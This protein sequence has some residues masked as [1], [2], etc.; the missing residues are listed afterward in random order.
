VSLTVAGRTPLRHSINQAGYHPEM[1]WNAVADALATEDPVAHVVHQETTFDAQE[2]RRHVT[3]L[4]L[5][6]TRL[7]MAHADEQET[8]G[9]PGVAATTEAVPLSRI[10]SVVMS[11]TY[12]RTGAII[13]AVLTIGW[14]AV[15]RI[16]LAPAHCADE[17]CDA[18]HGYSGTISSD[19]VQLRVAAAAEGSEAVAHL[20]AFGVALSAA[21]SR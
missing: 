14:G 2:V 4:A 10:G 11:K 18:D 7:I 8:L 3:V 5:T 15:S 1:V 13:D 20:V 17:N 16:D 9:G 6:P 21:T 19:D 12:E